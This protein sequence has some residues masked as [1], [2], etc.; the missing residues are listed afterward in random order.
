MV[1]FKSRRRHTRFDCDWSSDVCSSDLTLHTDLGHR[2]RA[3]KVDGNIVPLKYQLQNG[4][5]VEILTAKLGAPSRDWL[6]PQLGY[7]KSARTR[8]KVR[9]LFKNQNNGRRIAQGRLLLER[10]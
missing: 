9:P 5:R 4:Q 6:S 10:E 3:T 1:F 2:T 7:L 8:A